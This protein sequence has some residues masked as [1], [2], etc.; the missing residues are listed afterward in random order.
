MYIST[1]DMGRERSRTNITFLFEKYGVPNTMIEIGCFEGIT[2]FWV[3]EFGKIHNDK[4]KIYAIDPHTTLN[5][6]HA[7][8]FATIKRTFEYNLSKCVGNVSYINKYSYEALTE[9]IVAKEK[10]EFIFVDGDHT[11]AAVLEDMILSWRL[12][13]VGGVMLCD[14]SIGWKLVDEHGSA[15]VQLSPRMGIEMF[16]QSHWHKIE[17]IHLPDSF[18]TAFVKLKE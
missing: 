5:D 1:V 14:D 2:T 18:Q 4:F 15:P 16:I 9:L 7:F 6:N 8:D 17:L 11:S 3:S 13:P 12:L 10:A